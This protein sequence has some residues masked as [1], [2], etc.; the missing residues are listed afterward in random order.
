[1]FV[2]GIT[3]LLLIGCGSQVVL[4]DYQGRAYCNGVLT[5][6]QT[7]ETALHCVPASAVVLGEPYNIRTVTAQRVSYRVGVVD[8]VSDRATLVLAQ[9]V[10]LQ[11]YPRRLIPRQGVVATMWGGCRSRTSG[12]ITAIYLGERAVLLNGSQEFAIAD[13]WLVED[14]AVFCPRDSGAP[15]Y[16]TGGDYYGVFSGYRKVMGAQYG[17][18]GYTAVR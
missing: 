9:P 2:F 4:E 6:A 17:D 13:M 11:R 7:V 16:S 8:L 12:R 18:V 14:E 5:S 1:M 3:L 10:W 15:L